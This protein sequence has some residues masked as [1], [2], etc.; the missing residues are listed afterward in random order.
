MK[1]NIYI[2]AALI[3]GYAVYQRNYDFAI[4]SMLALIA[5]VLINLEK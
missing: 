4:W 5:M 2:I 1:R 3:S